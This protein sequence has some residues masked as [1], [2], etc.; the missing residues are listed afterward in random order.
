MRGEDLERDAPKLAIRGAI[1]L[2][3]AT[4]SQG[5][6][7]GVVPEVAADQRRRLPVRGTKA[8]LRLLSFR[9]SR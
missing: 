3:H 2:A 5:L 7:E 9:T 4:G 1:D 8:W 6:D